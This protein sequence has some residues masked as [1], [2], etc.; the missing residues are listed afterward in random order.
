VATV[1]RGSNKE[2][3]WVESLLF[4]LLLLLRLNAA[5]VAEDTTENVHLLWMLHQYSTRKKFSGEM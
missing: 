2:N 5:A 1:V 3:L 4:L